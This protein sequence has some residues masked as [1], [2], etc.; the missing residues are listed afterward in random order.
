VKL[1]I[2][3]KRHEKEEGE[4]CMERKV[5][6]GNKSLKIRTIQGDEKKV[7]VLTCTL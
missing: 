1:E 6:I 3:E 2:K 4:R 7:P 5:H